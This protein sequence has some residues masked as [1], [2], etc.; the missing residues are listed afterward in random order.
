M[1]PPLVPHGISLTCIF[2]RYK[3][4]S[5]VNT[6]IQSSQS[7]TWKIKRTWSVWSVTW[8]GSYWVIRGNF[9]WKPENFKI[10]F[11]K[12]NARTLNA[13]WINSHVFTPGSVTVC[14]SAPPLQYTPTWPSGTWCKMDKLFLI[15][16]DDGIT[17]YNIAIER[18][19]FP[20]STLK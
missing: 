10:W 3:K 15:L 13:T 9:R 4:D 8:T 20:G 1:T 14:R 2:F 7:M 18:H 11:H 5:N 16:D 6:A 12:Q 19:K 17:I